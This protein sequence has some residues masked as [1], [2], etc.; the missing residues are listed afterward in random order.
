MR[1]F[2]VK[3]SFLLKNSSGMIR[4]GIVWEGQAGHSDIW[5]F[6]E[7]RHLIQ[8]SGLTLPYK[9]LA[10]PTKLFFHLYLLPLVFFFAISRLLIEFVISKLK[11]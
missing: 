8:M 7:S 2:F 9:S 11:N 4:L 1:I 5:Q 3:I 10:D 6:L